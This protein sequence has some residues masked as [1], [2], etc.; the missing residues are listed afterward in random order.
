MS[1]MVNNKKDAFIGGLII[2]EACIRTLQNI[3]SCGDFYKKYRDNLIELGV[4][5]L[6]SL[7]PEFNMKLNTNPDY[8][9]L[10]LR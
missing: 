2:L 3:V 5:L 1:D 4:R 9:E 10:Y 6:N 8:H 7:E